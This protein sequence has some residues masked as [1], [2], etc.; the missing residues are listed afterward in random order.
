L[1]FKKD[2]EPSDGKAL[3]RR[4]DDVSDMGDLGSPGEIPMGSVEKLSERV[5]I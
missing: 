1:R 4:I 2:D 3:R 5:I